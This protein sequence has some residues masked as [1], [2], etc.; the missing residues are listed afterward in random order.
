MI[1]L[2]KNSGY[3]LFKKCEYISLSKKKSSKIY[4]EDFVS[5]HENVRLES[6]AIPEDLAGLVWTS[7]SY[8]MRRVL[9]SK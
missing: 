7:N 1:C 8:L 2:K 6:T 4:R 5:Y 3:I 9:I